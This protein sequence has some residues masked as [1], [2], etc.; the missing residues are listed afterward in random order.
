MAVSPLYTHCI[1]KFEVSQHPFMIVLKEDRF[2]VNR[3]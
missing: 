3:N 1:L 2:C